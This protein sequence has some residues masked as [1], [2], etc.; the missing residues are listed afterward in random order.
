MPAE[1]IHL[2]RR[3]SAGQQRELGVRDS[4]IMFDGTH[5]QI[6]DLAIE[7]GKRVSDHQDRGGIPGIAQSGCAQP[8]LSGPSGFGGGATGDGTNA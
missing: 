6:Q 7:E 8:V 1:M 5:H 3:R 2:R 4:Q